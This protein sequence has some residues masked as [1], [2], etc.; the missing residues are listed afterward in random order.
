MC[1]WL[2]KIRASDVT[3]IKGYVPGKTLGKIL[4]RIAKSPPG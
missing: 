4:T 3:E 1:N 2:V